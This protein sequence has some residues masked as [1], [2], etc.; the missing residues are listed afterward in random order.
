MRDAQTRS[1]AQTW[2]SADDLKLSAIEDY[3]HLAKEGWMP[4]TFGWKDKIDKWVKKVDAS[5]EEH[6]V[7]LLEATGLM[8]Y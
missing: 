5:C 6:E 7:A 8:D 3:Q 2:R 1:R 4:L